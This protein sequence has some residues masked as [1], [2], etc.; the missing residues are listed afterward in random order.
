MYTKFFGFRENPF[1]NVPDP[2]FFC[3]S[4]SNEASLD[5]IMET[6]ERAGEVLVVT[7]ARGVGKTVTMRFV[8]EHVLDERFVPVWFAEPPRSE[9]ALA[10]QALH[11]L[12]VP[13]P[14]E[15]DAKTLLNALLRHAASLQAQSQRLLLVIDDAER[16]EGRLLRLLV[17]LAALT[18]E[19][20]PLLQVAL[21]GE[22]TILDAFPDGDGRLR[23]VRI[24]PLE[25]KDLRGY[26]LHRLKVVGWDGRP[27]IEEGLYLPLF[28]ATGGNPREVNRLA[29]RLLSMAM[30]CE[31]PAV[32]AELLNGLLASKGEARPSHDPEPAQVSPRPA[33]MGSQG[34]IPRE[35]APTDEGLAVEMGPSPSAKDDLD[36]EQ[37]EAEYGLRRRQRAGQAPSRALP[38]LA[39]SRAVLGLAFLSLAASGTFFWM[40]K[41]GL[42]IQW[43]FAQAA[44]HAPS[45]THARSHERHAEPAASDTE[46]AFGKKTEVARY[47][48]E[49][50][51]TPLFAS[52][53]G[54]TARLK[55]PANAGRRG[56]VTDAHEDPRKR[57]ATAAPRALGTSRLHRYPRITT[58]TT[59]TD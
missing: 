35:D 52:P 57:K 4:R 9:T 28:E 48:L 32:T 15:G 55:R 1:K 50:V 5:G 38:R 45:D 24:V 42:H 34:H 11:T 27:R 16:L 39:A 18:R 59:G 49:D 13:L 36:L 17:K 22:E 19:G 44:D 33:A 56:P 23:V 10:Q 53:S 7:G 3:I 21:V 37:L 26:L 46:H 6:L 40:Q 8:L 43:P 29:D 58:N 41:N 14:P 51:V 20:A 30:L 25:L 2:R 12:S 31:A 47:R 54:R